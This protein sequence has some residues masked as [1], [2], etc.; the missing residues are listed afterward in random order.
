MKMLPALEEEAKK[1]QQFHG[2]TAPGKSLP[3]LVGEVISCGEAAAVAAAVMPKA[4]GGVLSIQKT[5]FFPERAPP[6]ADLFFAGM[7]F[8]AKSVFCALIR[9]GAREFLRRNPQFEN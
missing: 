2:G 9:D 6:H 8:H 7:E 3:P 1:R 5:E 4:R